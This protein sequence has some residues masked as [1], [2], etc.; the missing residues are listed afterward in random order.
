MVDQIRRCFALVT[1]VSMDLTGNPGGSSQQKRPRT[2]RWVKYHDP[3]A[4]K[5]M[6][7]KKGLVEKGHDTCNNFLAVHCNIYML[8]HGRLLP[9][10]RY[11]RLCEIGLQGSAL[12]LKQKRPCAAIR[13]CFHAA[14]S[15]WMCCIVCHGLP[16]G[17]PVFKP[18]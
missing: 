1:W 18:N 3:V 17:L 7:L 16:S 2:A 6:I 12:L 5:G 8:R 14:L 9:Q 15:C 10:G 13:D 11:V 4:W